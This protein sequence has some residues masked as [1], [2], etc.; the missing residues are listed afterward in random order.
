MTDFCR[1]LLPLLLVFCLF[2]PVAASFAADAPTQ[3]EQLQR[4]NQRLHRQLHDARREI[5][6]LKEVETEPGWPQAV[7]GIGVIFGLCGVAMMISARRR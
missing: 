1:R 7:A 4:E 6:R 2:A 5:A 3:L